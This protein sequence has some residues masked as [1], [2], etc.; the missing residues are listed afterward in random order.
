MRKIQFH[1]ALTMMKHKN[2]FF[3]EDDG[4]FGGEGST[5]ESETQAT[6]TQASLA[7]DAKSLAEQFGTV[8]KEQFQERDKKETQNRP[9]TPEE[10]AAARAQFGMVDIDDGF[11][12][13]FDNLETR[14]TALQ[15]YTDRIYES[16]S[17]ITQAMLARQQAAFEERLKPFE[18]QLVQRQVAEQMSR[19]HG[20]Y[21]QLANEN[22]APVI[23]AVGTKLAEQN[24]FNGLSESAAMDKLAEG[25]ASVLRISNPSFSL[26]TKTNGK[27]SNEIPTETTGSRGGGGHASGGVSPDSPNG[28]FGPVRSKR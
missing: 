4:Q 16:Q 2:L 27:S 15:K 8:L 28:V 1:T 23:Q 17:K 18:E 19:F 5:T 25:V 3:E 10:R 6:Q 22:L 24:A 9:P 21:P 11:L 20:K 13:E 12:T 7:F 14:K 26:T